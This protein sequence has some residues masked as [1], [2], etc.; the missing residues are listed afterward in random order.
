MAT[1]KST[2]Y[3]DMIERDIE[4]IWSI[5]NYI[6]RNGW[7]DTVMSRIVSKHPLQ[8]ICMVIWMFF[9]FGVIEIGSRHFWVVALNTS[10]AFGRIS[11][12][13]MSVKTNSSISSPY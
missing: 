11:N 5:H 6:M 8:D 10:L 7:I 9:A 1:T 12:I 13:L 2:N 3:D 4:I